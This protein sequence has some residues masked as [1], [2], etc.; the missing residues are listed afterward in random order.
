MLVGDNDTRSTAISHSASAAITVISIDIGKNSFH[1]VG[2]DERDAV[3][4][5]ER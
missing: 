5:R 3:A 2:H 4:L 1:V